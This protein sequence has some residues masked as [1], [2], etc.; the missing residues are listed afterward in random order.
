MGPSPSD[1]T[2]ILLPLWQRGRQPL[3]A[4]DRPWSVPDCGPQPETNEV[5][6]LQLRN[7]L[8]L[9]GGCPLLSLMLLGAAPGVGAEDYNGDG[10]DDADDCQAEKGGGGWGGQ[11]V[12]CP[13]GS[14]QCEAYETLA[15][16]VRSGDNDAYVFGNVDCGGSNEHCDGTQVCQSPPS[17]PTEG[18]GDGRCWGGSDE[19]WKSYIYIKCTSAGACVL[20]A[21]RGDPVGAV[22][23]ILFN[24]TQGIVGTICDPD[25]VPTVPEVSLDEVLG[26]II[27]ILPDPTLPGIPEVRD[28][29]TPVLP[30]LPPWE[31]PDPT[32]PEPEPIILPDPGMLDVD[33]VLAYLEQLLNLQ[34][35]EP[36]ELGLV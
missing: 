32:L 10:Y 16:T 33:P 6:R 22:V 36:P 11:R 1:A 3:A 23:G 17:K 20:P 4:E 14:F 28:P 30:E 2:R 25:C 27:G 13:A 24:A 15:V 7:A 8:R 26:W 29:E 18:S 5:K 9:L 12:E 31:V 21:C 34:P 19:L 35:A